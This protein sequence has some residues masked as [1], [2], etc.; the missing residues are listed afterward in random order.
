MRRLSRLAD[1][2]AVVGIAISV[3]LALSLDLT[4]AAS[5]V[6]SL[7]AGMMGATITLV[8]DLGARAERRFHLRGQLESAEWIGPAVKPV[9]DHAEAIGRTYPDS[10]VSAEARRRFRLLATELDGLRHGRISR[11]HG[12]CEYLIGGAQSCRDR[13]D[14]VTNIHP[15]GEHGTGWWSSEVGRR[16]W[17]ANLAAL[18]RGVAVTR[19]FVYSRPTDGLRALVDTQLA[20]GVTVVLLPRP[21]TDPALRLNMAMFDDRTAW[22]ARMSA[23]GE[24]VENL[25]YVCDGEVDRL[26][27][28]FRLAVMNGSTDPATLL[29][30]PRAAAGLTE[31]A[32]D[33]AG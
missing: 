9:L 6:E 27:T 10:E 1:P 20:A 3:A 16:Y 14:A 32:G 15:G 7:L 5:G 17:Q 21:G 30:G 26:R 18:A 19:V 24:I 12:D 13:I 25:F 4:D 33:G 11:P 31:P 28:A 8:I 29:A 23:D 2:I 22:E